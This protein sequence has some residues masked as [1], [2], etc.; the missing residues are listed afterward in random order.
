MDDEIVVVRLESRRRPALFGA[1]T[2]GI[3]RYGDSAQPHVE[4][5]ADQHAS[6]RHDR[7][8]D[9]PCAAGHG[10]GMLPKDGAVARSE[11]RCPVTGQHDEL[12]D[13]AD[14]REVSRAVAQWAGRREPSRLSRREIVC[15]NCLAIRSSRVND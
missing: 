5:G 15:H 10:P 6:V 14:R 7:G 4:A 1:P 11:T 2:S 3:E 9:D 12:P 13:P 8:L